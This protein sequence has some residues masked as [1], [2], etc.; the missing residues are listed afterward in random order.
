MTKQLCVRH[1]VAGRELARRGA[2]RPPL[3]SVMALLRLEAAASCS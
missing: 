3:V 2:V 1:C